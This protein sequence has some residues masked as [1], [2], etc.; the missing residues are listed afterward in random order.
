MSSSDRILRDGA[1]YGS[2]SETLVGAAELRRRIAEEQVGG[3]YAVARREGYAQGM[4]EGREEGL[5]AGRE[6]GLK[7][8][9][10]EALG[11]DQGSRDRAES[12]RDAATQKFECELRAALS[13][14]QE[15]W[16]AWLARAE[17]DLAEAAIRTAERALHSHLAIRRDDVVAMAAHALEELGHGKAFRIR[18][19][20]M[21]ESILESRREEIARIL[22][23]SAV[24]EII[25]DESIES[26]VIIESNVGRADARPATY[27]SE[28]RKEAA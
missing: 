17:Q 28:L 6:E 4:K 20:P 22:S 13:S 12:E 3:E 2:F 15:E 7:Q 5:K 1:A 14:F 16:A 11:Q 27:F 10:E 18:C 8:G 19:A 23:Q 24:V 9:R 26:G 25:P 21:D